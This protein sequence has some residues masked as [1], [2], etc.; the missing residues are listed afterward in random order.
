MGPSSGIASSPRKPRLCAALQEVEAR[1]PAAPCGMCSPHRRRQSQ[2]PHAGAA[3]AGVAASAPVGSGRRDFFFKRPNFPAVR[4][5][6]SSSYALDLRGAVQMLVATAHDDAEPRPRRRRRARGYRECGGQAPGRSRCSPTPRPRPSARRWRRSQTSSTS[7]ATGSKRDDAGALSLRGGLV[8]GQGPR[9]MALAPAY[10]RR[11]DGRV[12]CAC[13]SAAPR[14]QRTDGMAQW[15]HPGQPRRGKRPSRRRVS[16]PVRSPGLRF[17][18]RLYTE[19]AKGR[20][21]DDAFCL[22]RALTSRRRPVA[23]APLLY[24]RL[25]DPARADP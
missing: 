24:R 13:S 22:T 6:G 2:R 3:P 5:A 18:E 10:E 17:M 19:L 12:V 9:G 11:P 25:S 14:Q 20:D 16:R 8:R 21:L 1:P 4:C 15:D 7:P 23:G